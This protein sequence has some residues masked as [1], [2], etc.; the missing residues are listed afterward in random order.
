MRLIMKRTFWIL[1]TVTFVVSVHSATLKSRRFKEPKP[2]TEMKAALDTVRSWSDQI[3]VV[4][5]F[6]EK[7]PDEI[8][9]QLYALGFRLA[10]NPRQV[11]AECEKMAKEKPDNINA[12]FLAGRAA[13]NPAIQLD[14]GQRILEKDSQSY[15]GHYM[16]GGYYTELMLPNYDDAEKSFLKAIEIDNSLPYAFRNLGKLYQLQNKTEKADEVFV[17]MGEMMPDDFGPVQLRITLRGADYKESLKLTQAFSK[18][19]PQSARAYE[20]EA[21]LQRELRDWPGYVEAC[22]RLLSVQREGGNAYNLACAFSLGGETDSAFASLKLATELG[23]NDIDQYKE[24]EDLIPLHE[25]PRWSDLLVAVEDAYKQEMMKLRQQA[26]AT[27]IERRKQALRSRL[28]DPAPDW[29]LKDLSGSEVSLSALRG[30]IVILDFWATWCGPCRKTM[31][32]IDK[33]FRANKRDDVKVFGINVWERKKGPPEVKAYI[34]SKGYE[35]PILLG[36]ETIASDYGVRGIPT[37][38]VID[39]DGKIAFRHVG[40]DPNMDEVLTWQVNHIL[41]PKKSSP[42]NQ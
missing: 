42:Q 35:F 25:D 7:H 6:V 2:L 15:W 20:M 32:L 13:Q 28:D 23:Y 38:F 10:D 3:N 4:K 27:V 18:K 36:S 22:R 17:L 29:A 40:F 14:Y 11:R 1:L 30:N 21:R 41:N 26:R 31:P 37:L 5:D 19:H 24:D 33:F 34:E 16:L 39:P 8:E 12:L 9:L